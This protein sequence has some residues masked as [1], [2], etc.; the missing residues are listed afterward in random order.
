MQE[1][2]LQKIQ[3]AKK[4]GW[5]ALE[6]DFLNLKRLPSEI[7]TL[8][9]LRELDLEG[10]ELTSL[11]EEIS[12]MTSLEKLRLS[13]NPIKE[14]PQEMG[15][16]ESLKHLYL[17]NTKLET[18]PESFANLL[19]IEYLTLNS[20]QIRTLSDSLWEWV[21]SVKRFALDW[22]E[23]ESIQF[24]YTYDS[25]DEEDEDNDYE[26][27]ETEEEPIF[28][29]RPYLTRI[30]ERFG[31]VADMFFSV[32]LKWELGVFLQE[33]G[34]NVLILQ[35][36]DQIKICVDRILDEDGI[37]VLHTV[38]ANLELVHEDMGIDDVGRYFIMSLIEDEW[39]NGLNIN[40]DTLLRLHHW[41]DTEYESLSAESKLSV[42][43]LMEF[44]HGEQGRRRLRFN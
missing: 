12:Q 38:R 31:E 42:E 39:G 16:M 24:Y 25:I 20:S 40:Y 21:D 37:E 43:E 32:K 34:V 26:G 27:E 41:G 13:N 2:V 9:E 18:L 30:I 33:R 28:R 1:G 5:K 3:D 22:E 17:D 11:P 10:N 6:L 35:D 19:N 15:R 23:I 7:G 14:L 44:I 36:W 29:P 4:E 8:T